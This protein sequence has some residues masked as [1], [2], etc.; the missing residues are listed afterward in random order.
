MVTTEPPPAASISGSAARAVAT[1]EYA[2]MSTAIQNRSRGVSVKRPS[3][4]SAAANAT[5]WTRR[6]S[7]PPNASDTSENTRAIAASSRTSSSVTSGLPTVSARSRTP[8]SMRSPWYVKA[9]SAP[10]CASRF[11]IAHAIER[12]FATPRIN[13]F[14]PSNMTGDFR[15]H[16]LLCGT[17]RRPLMVMAAIGLLTATSAS[18]ALTPIRRDAREAALPRV[19]AGNLEIPA[20]AQHGLTRVIVRLAA[21][22]LAAWS[23]DRT[24]LSASRSRRLNV[25]SAS[26]R[27]YLAKLARLQQAA[28]AQVRAAVPAAQ[29]QEHYSILL[30][31]F[32]VQLPAKSL[33]KLLSVSAVT[34][35]YPSLAYTATMDRGPSVIKATD[36]QAATGD[37]GQ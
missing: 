9:S 4:S 24:V 34:K 21:P 8:F 2:L 27:A 19:R 3:R 23:A 10:P 5:E 36:L 26:S 14:F 30:D 22:P 35:I 17:L 25:A 37:K 28:V 32:A 18:A 11:A 6:S 20:P 31:G 12:L 33:P 29:V 15:S 13:A 16:W 1:S 7:L